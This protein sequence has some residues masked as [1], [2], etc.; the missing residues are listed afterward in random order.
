MC[1][2]CE[3]LKNRRDATIKVNNPWTP[4][5]WGHHFN[6]SDAGDGITQL[7]GVNTKSVDALAPKVA[8][9]SAGMVLI[10]LDRQNALLF[11]S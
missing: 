9:A 4:G 2:I 6:S 11:Q 3:V 1:F 5:R 10:V 7:C 8:R